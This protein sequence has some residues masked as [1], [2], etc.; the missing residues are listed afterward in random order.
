MS[1]YSNDSK[2][3]SKLTNAFVR[4]LCE[5]SNSSKCLKIWKAFGRRCRLQLLSESLW[6][7]GKW[8]RTTVKSAANIGLPLKFNTRSLLAFLKASSE[9]RSCRLQFDRSNDWRLC[10]LWPNVFPT[11]K[12]HNSLSA[13]TNCLRYKFCA[14]AS[15]GRLVIPVFLMFKY[16]NRTKGANTLVQLNVRKSF[17]AISSS[18]R[19]S[20]W[21]NAI[22]EMWVKLQ[23]FSFRYSK[24]ARWSNGPGLIC[25]SGLWDKSSLFRF[26]VLWKNWVFRW[27]I[28][29]EFKSR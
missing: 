26:V 24:L 25:P 23:A 21:A 5:M 12:C 1:R 27:R 13:R 17:S 8:R 14:N 20:K 4:G 29:H 7:F 22:D 15:P 28:P 3:F 6:S 10:R 9:S 19:F 11:S 18:R 16:S 2:G